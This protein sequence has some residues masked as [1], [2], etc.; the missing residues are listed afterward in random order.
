MSN[1]ELY[2]HGVKGQRWGVRRYQ[3]PDGTLT[4]AGQRRLDKFKKR[5]GK[6]LDKR[7]AAVEK[8]GDKAEERERNKALKYKSKAT[9]LAVINKYETNEKKRAKNDKKFEKYYNKMEQSFKRQEAVN[10]DFSAYK[11]KLRNE[12]KT[13]MNYSF[14]D[15]KRENKEYW[16]E[17]IKRGN[18]IYNHHGALSYAALE[19]TNQTHEA[20]AYIRELIANEK[21]PTKKPKK[22]VDKTIRL[23]N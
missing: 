13:V 21:N 14:E 20:R 12:K 5:Q 3:N 10:A 2:H 7:L 23:S 17:C 15:M 6:A 4:P 19:Q 11:E 18:A 8:S 22:E 9:A 16:G 1:D